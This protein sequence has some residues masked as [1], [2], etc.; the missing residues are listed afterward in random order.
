[1]GFISDLSMPSV[2][3]QASKSTGLR[4]FTYETVHRNL[5]TRLFSRTTGLEIDIMITPLLKIV[6]V[7][8]DSDIVTARALVQALIP[9]AAA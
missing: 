9:A 3:L 4:S 8:V 1:L 2:N 7:P 6:T 5:C